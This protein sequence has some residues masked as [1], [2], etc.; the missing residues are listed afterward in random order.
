MD[1]LAPLYSRS[2]SLSLYYLAVYRAACLPVP[3]RETCSAWHTPWRSTTYSSLSL[4][5][6]NFALA[7]R[8]YTP[9]PS[10]NP[11]NLSLTH[12]L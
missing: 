9:F 7:N 10:L 2:L 5:H 12:S 1:C 4:S 11:F 6:L 8:P 3:L